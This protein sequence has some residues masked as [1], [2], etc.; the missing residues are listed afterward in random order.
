MTHRIVAP[1][2]PRTLTDI[3]LEGV[4]LDAPRQ[5]D[6]LD[7]LMPA[8]RLVEMYLAGKLRLDELITKRHPLSEINEA[9]QALAAGE[10][11]RGLLVFSS[12]LSDPMCSE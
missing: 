11:A 12:H 9:H 8:P 5:G 2:L 4:E 3:M 1:M 6:L 10:N 7:R